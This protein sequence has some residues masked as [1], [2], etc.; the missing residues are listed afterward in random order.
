MNQDSGQS[1]SEAGSKGPSHNNIKTARDGTK[2]YSDGYEPP[3]QKLKGKITSVRWGDGNIYTGKFSGDTRAYNDS[4]VSTRIISRILYKFM[5]DDGDVKWYQLHKTAA[6]AADRTGGS[7]NAADDA[8]AMADEDE[9]EDDVKLY[10]LHKTVK[11]DIIAIDTNGFVKRFFFGPKSVGDFPELTSHPTTTSGQNTQQ[12]KSVFNTMVS[13]QG[14]D[15]ILPDYSR[16]SS[17][18]ESVGGGTR[19]RKTRKRKKTQKKRRKKKK[20]KRRKKKKTRRK[21]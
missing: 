14:T 8:A 18:T 11:D 12:I 20:K 16:E 2:Y 3:A 9:D 6:A 5:Y 21:K 10:Q 15:K 1:S 17:V 19:K 13:T 4:N 7:E